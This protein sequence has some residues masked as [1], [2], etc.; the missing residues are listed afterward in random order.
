MT[1][2]RTVFQLGFQLS[3]IILTDG[4]ASLIPG[5]M[6]PI[7]ALT[8]ATSFVLGLLGGSGI[9]GADQC[10]AHWRPLP[11]TTL[12]QNQIGAYPFA[13]QSVAAN[14][15]VQQPNT[16]SMLMECPVQ[17]P[18]GY[19]AKLATISAMKAALNQ[20]NA[21]G[22]TYIVATPSN[23]FTNCILVSVRDVSTGQSHQSQTAWQFDF[24][25]PL[26]TVDQAQQVYSA[27]MNKIAGGLPI[28]GQPSWSGLAS[29][30][31]T[32]IAGAVSTVVPSLSSLT[33]ALASGVAT[34]GSIL[35]S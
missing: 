3:P 30:V 7:I 32:N 21:A 29:T 17:Q 31:G 34:A 4:L 12:V 11:G 1:F 26:V 16:V 9:P 18:G 2:G 27:L 33:G 25:Q 13:N 6:L 5:Q 24:V 10:F 22:G 15:L 19:T 14:A 20:H 23:I 28:S 35:S 8:E